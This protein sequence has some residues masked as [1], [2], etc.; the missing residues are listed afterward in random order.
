[1]KFLTGV[2]MTAVVSGVGGSFI[3][4]MID[5]GL[6]GGFGIALGIW[7]I[8]MSVLCG[9]ERIAEAIENKKA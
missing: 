1:M 9:T 4:Q 7:A 5:G 2:I 3:S 8:C 6:L